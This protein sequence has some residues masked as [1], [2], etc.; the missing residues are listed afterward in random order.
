MSGL[1]SGRFDADLAQR[2]VDHAGQQ[3][4]LHRLAAEAVVHVRWVFKSQHVL[5][6]GRHPGDLVQVDAV[7]ALQ[8]AARPQPGGDGVAAVDPD[9]AALQVLR[10]PDAGIDVMEDRP[11]MKIPRHEQRDRGERQAGRAGA[12][13]GRERHLADVEFEPAAHAAHHRDDLLD[14]DKFQVEPPK[15]HACLFDRLGQPVIPQRDRQR[16]HRRLPIITGTIA[17]LPSSVTCDQIARRNARLGREVLVTHQQ[18][19]VR[20]PIWGIK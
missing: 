19:S 13:I 16:L 5:V 14:L 15:I 7:L 6:V 8:D 3:Q 1:I 2:R 10:R 4:L 17:V 18:T 11:V 12:D 20:E 9:L